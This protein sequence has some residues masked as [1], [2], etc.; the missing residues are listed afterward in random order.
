MVNRSSATL[1]G[2]GS[3]VV[4]P[5]ELP[6]PVISSAFRLVGGGQIVT[7]QEG[8]H[9][10]EWNGVSHVSCLIGKWRI[11]GEARRWAV[12]LTVWVSGAER[13]ET[14]HR[15]AK[16][17]PTISLSSLVGEKVGRRSSEDPRASYPSAPAGVREPRKAAVANP[18]LA[19]HPGPK[20]RNYLNQPGDLMG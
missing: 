11:G 17:V 10:G 5:A 18:I 8:E 15:D 19:V 7:R 13:I 1:S 6:I 14:R 9:A 4:A 2:I 16:G 3:E 20:V 12:Q